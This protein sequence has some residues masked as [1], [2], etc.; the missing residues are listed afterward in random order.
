MRIQAIV[1]DFDGVILDSELLHI[2][3]EYETFARFGLQPQ[4]SLMKQYFGVKLE[5]YFSDIARK[6]GL[7]SSLEEMIAAHYETLKHYYSSLFPLVPHVQTV[8]SSLEKSYKMAVATSREE[9]LAVLALQRYSLMGYFEAMVYG[10]DVKS[11]K[12]DPEPFCKACRKL[13]IDPVAAVAVEDAEAGFESA[14]RAGMHVIARRGKHNREVD[15]S[16]AHAVIEDLRDIE[17]AIAKI[18]REL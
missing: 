11:G 10:E 9:E 14:G 5:D 1:W 13:N 18:E 4:E 6:F 17:D 8:L 15:F 16:R 7:G 12:P 3:A 2:K